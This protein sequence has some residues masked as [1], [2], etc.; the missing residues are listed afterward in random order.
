MDSLRDDHIAGTK[1]LKIVVDHVDGDWTETTRR[2][3]ELQRLMGQIANRF[4]R[5][6]IALHELNESEAKYKTWLDSRKTDKKTAGDCPVEF[7]PPGFTKDMNQ[8]A[9]DAAGLGHLHSRCAGLLV[10][11]MQQDYFSRKSEKVPSL[12]RWQAILLGHE[13][14]PSF[15]PLQPIRFD[16]KNSRIVSV[17]GKMLIE[18]SGWRTP[19]EGKTGISTVDTLHL[20]CVGQRDRQQYELIKRIESGEWK[21]RGSILRYD[22]AAKKWMVHLCYAFDQPKPKS[23]DPNKVAYLR[24]GSKVAFLI[25]ERGK[26]ATWLQRRGGH[27]TDY[28]ERLF[29]LRLNKAAN[30]RVATNRKGH[31]FRAANKWRARSE[32]TWRHFTKRINQHVANDAIKWCQANGCGTLVYQMPAGRYAETRQVAGDIKG[33][34]WPYFDLQTILNYKANGSGVN[35]VVHKCGEGRETVTKPAKGVKQKAKTGV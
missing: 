17:G 29:Q 5:K 28:R 35:V 20:K 6:W 18:L 3:F 22:D 8:T 27:I 9:L 1:V 30:Y 25:R 31:G 26:R 24:C 21:A 4:W 12:K 10:N 11:V 7:L 14:I 23:L 34:T 16:N 19:R 2:W 33:S 32:W 13:A 15:M